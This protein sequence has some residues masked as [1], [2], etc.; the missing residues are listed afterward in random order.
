LYNVY[1]RYIICLSTRQRLKRNLHRQ[2]RHVAERKDATMSP[3]S[4]D[5]HPDPL[6]Y[7]RFNPPGRLPCRKD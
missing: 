2:S 4:D 1:T 5:G 7:F 3:P 6:C